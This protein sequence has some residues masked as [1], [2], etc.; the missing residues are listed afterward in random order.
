MRAHVSRSSESCWHVDSGAEGQCD[1][2]ADAGNGHETAREC[3]ITCKPDQQIIQAAELLA[4]NPT[5]IE[6][7]IGD[8]MQIA[9]AEQFADSRF[10][11]ACCDL[12]EMVAEVADETPDLVLDI[13]ELVSQQL[14][15]GR[16]HV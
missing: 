8:D 4:K 7:R 5:C 11:L 10:E 12:A 6:Q 15:I 1:H 14:E 3:I 16:A 13:L 9:L 2:R